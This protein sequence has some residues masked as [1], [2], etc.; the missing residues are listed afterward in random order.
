MASDSVPHYSPEQTVASPPENRDPHSLPCPPACLDSV[1]RHE[2]T[3]QNSFLGPQKLSTQF[4]H[5]SLGLASHFLWPRLLWALAHLSTTADF[6]PKVLG[7]TESGRGRNRS[8]TAE[9]GVRF[10][11][12][13][14]TLRA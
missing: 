5:T 7:G 4:L 9:T 1:R 6:L 8:R 2:R 14:V 12:R 13:T 11:F 3:H 10:Q